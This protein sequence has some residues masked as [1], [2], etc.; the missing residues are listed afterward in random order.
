[1]P[2]L[3]AQSSASGT[4]SG[5][6]TD[7]QSALVAEAEVV[8]T[9]TS[10]NASQTITTN[11]V[12]R[13]IFLNV[14]PGTYNLTVG[15][16]G[17]ERAR[18][19]AQTVQVGLVLTL[20]V[21]LEVGSTATT[22]EVHASAGA[23][24]QT[25]NAT[26][27]TT[28]T[29]RALNTLPN[30]GRDA[31]AFFVLQPAVAPGGQVSGAASDQTLFQLDGGNN[32]SDQDGTYAN[33][34]V[35]SGTM[36]VA[37]GGSPSGVIPTP[38]ESIEEFKVG[39]NNQTADF[40]GAAGGQ[41]QMVTKRGT[42][43]FHGAAY[44]YYFGSNFGANTWKND[45]TPSASSPFTPL[46]S[47]HQNRFGAAIGGPLTPS[48]RGSKTYFFFNYEG[49]RFPQAVTVDRIVP[50]PLLRA[51]V[52][53]V[54]N[55][56]GQWQ[57]YNLN[58]FPVTVNG[59][60]YQPAMCAGQICDPRG[61]GLNPLISR[62]WNKYMPL[63][64]DPQVGDRF[65]TQGYL[66]PV[67]LPLSSN[68]AVARID[69]DLS[70][71]WRF[72]ASYRYYKLTQF[73]T[74][75]VDIGGALPGDTFGVASAKTQR[76]QTPSYWVGGLTGVIRPNLVNDFRYSYLRNAWQWSSVGA[77]A[78]LPGLG[79]AIEPYADNSSALVPY[80]VDRGDALA[81]FWDGQDNMISDNLSLVSGNHLFQFGGQYQRDFD[82]HQRNDNGVNIISSVVYQAN[83]GS[84][85]SIPSNYIPATVPANQVSNWDTLYATTLGMISQPQVFYARS[86]GNLLPVGSSIFSQSVI[87]SYNVYFSDTWKMKPSFTLTYGLGWDLQM[88]PYELHGN[89]PMLVD[90]N[91]N[92]IGGEDYLAKRKAA[93]LAGQV[94]NPI[95]GFSTVRNV[96]KG[97]KYPYDPFYGG[98]SPRL[99]A[100][101]N[102]KYSDGILGKVL[103]GGKT[104]FR[105]GYS[106]VWARMNGI[107][108]VQVP[109]QGTGIGQGVA[110]VGA[111]IAGQ[112]LGNAG[113]DPT[114]AFRIGTD[115][116]TAP[117]PGVSQVLPQPFFPGI[118]GNA[119]A[120][121]SWAIDP[122]NLKPASTD[123]F[124][125]TIQ[126]EITNRVSV[127]IGY[128]GRLM[129]GEQ[130]AYSLDSV[131]Y[132]TTLNGQTFSQAFANIYRQLNAGGAVATQPWFE[133]A[134]GG[135]GS[136][137]CSAFASCTAAVA[138]KQ[139]TNILTT[140]VYDFWGALNNAPGW[141]LGQTMPSSNPLQVSA[142]PMLASIG[143]SNY[144][145]AF[146]SFH[147][148]EWHGVT[149]TSNLTFSRSFGTGG[150]TQAGTPSILDQWNLRSMYGVQPFDI[151]WVH[152][153]LMVY[154]PP[155]F[156]GR[157]GVLGQLLGGW[158][159]APL[160]TAQSGVPLPVLISGGS[161]NS[162]QSFG[163][164]SCTSVGTGN[165]EN[166]VAIAPLSRGNS[167]NYNLAST[168]AGSSG[169]PSSGGSGINIFG[170][171]QAVLSGFRRMILGVDS[172]GG[173]AGVLRG[174]PTWNLDLAV[175]KDI[176]IWERV[177]MTFN[178]SSPMWRT[179]SSQPIQR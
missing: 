160:F 105:G 119:P 87:P 135:A 169:N 30:L 81:R 115:G 123:Q 93:A 45:H 168:G 159:F 165:H 46:P 25:T 170:N 59:T 150:F 28:I 149:A 102:P 13:Y 162:C 4:V 17:F 15:K 91:N 61:V 113:V 18:F 85:I 164:A 143:Y 57:P 62:M 121:T 67:P 14:A 77:P 11:D 12:G 3:G 134:L 124:D 78:Q 24:L 84:G 177:G 95:I 163:E 141:T 137:Y 96:G 166:A 75:Q 55:G 27:G 146:A 120:G 65:N 76:P 125:F 80:Q 154:R 106:R 133:S 151:K 42:N 22:I 173:G 116:L 97:R 130:V 5:L 109:L 111:S 131:P 117:L 74:N 118:N 88:P 98:F 29:G 35:S 26:V 50:T 167:A 63:P 174:F 23:E 153:T 104:V 178:S 138:S 152:N 156:G 20:D 148:N 132:M 58:P 64:N 51:G 145:G 1:M 144:N 90:A 69:R 10:T 175:T 32:S 19:L 70:T 33:Y 44:E 52:V 94:Y 89:Q 142:I 99:A 103:G 126:R 47:T 43:Q 172:N 60:T 31:N 66:A 8:L 21:T 54:Q 158:S 140:R 86:G 108:L 41:V 171:P 2:T 79:G 101:W 71:N 82:K 72:M 49:R 83:Y 39:T 40:N 107:N 34:T 53:Q 37:S 73:T 112:C 157:H 161:G 36:G 9:D 68:F 110:C 122:T 176:K 129:R 48:I 147:M 38:V 114:T 6:I 7:K 128:V 92:P 155:Y 16:P 139:K 56:S 127:E 136:A 100:A 179:T